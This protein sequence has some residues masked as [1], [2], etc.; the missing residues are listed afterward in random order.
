VIFFALKNTEEIRTIYPVFLPI[1]FLINAL[2]PI[3]NYII[4]DIDGHIKGT[5]CAIPYT[6]S[7]VFL[8][9]D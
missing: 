8:H 1:A 4:L 2:L 7:A 6:I 9:K 3:F 5:K